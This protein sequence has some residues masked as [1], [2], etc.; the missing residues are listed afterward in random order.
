VRYLTCRRCGLKVKTEERLMVP[1]SEGDFMTLVAQAFPDDTVVG[2][3]TLRTHG[4]LSRGLSRVNTHLIPH[5][6]QLELVR[7]QGR[8]VGVVRRRISPE[9]PERTSDEVDTG[10]SWR[11]GRGGC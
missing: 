7:H 11:H 5:G 8:V 3:A 1:W 10:R 4:L 2:V 9:A 6:W